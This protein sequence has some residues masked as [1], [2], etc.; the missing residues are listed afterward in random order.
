MTDIDNALEMLGG[1]GPEFGAF[2]LSNHGPMAAEALC[3]LGRGEDVEQWVSKYKKRL[4]DQ[5][6]R[7]APIGPDGWQEALGQLERVTDWEDFFARELDAMPWREVLELW[8]PRLA[9]GMMA[10]AT[11]G[12]IRTAHAVRSLAAEEDSEIRR[13]EFVAGL[14]YWAARYQ[15]MPGVLLPREPRLPSEA[16]GDVPIFPGHLRKPRPTSIFTAVA[17]LDDYPPFAKVIN[18]AAPGDDVGA[19]ISDLT[20]VMA[21]LYLE[22]AGPGSIAY[23][24]TVTAPSALRMLLPHISL[25]TAKVGARY[26][27]EACAAIHSRGHYPHEVVLPETMPS[28]DDL[29]DR[30]VFSGDEHAIK[31]TEACLRENA[32]RPD[33]AFFAGPLHMSERYGKKTRE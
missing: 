32:L 5:P 14:A 7:V 18:L 21:H 3:A 24:H 2:G 17:E 10:G 9:V 25:E 8:L 1:C 19:F 11:H 27:W 28:R 29:I 22:N 31:Y 26:A 33:P 6:A 23:V 15:V 16:L 13:A 4:I 30:A 20:Q 12:L